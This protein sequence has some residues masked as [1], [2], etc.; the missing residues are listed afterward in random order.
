MPFKL[1]NA[2]ATILVGGQA[3]R[4]GGRLK[5]ALAIGAETI[6]ERQLAAIRDAGSTEILMIGRWPAPAI[7]GLRHF[8]DVIDG[9]G[10]LGGLYSALL[11][12]TSST[13]LV[14]AGDLPFISAQLLRQLDTMGAG[15]DA[16]VPRIDG[17]WHP[18]CAAYRRTVAGAI[19]QRIAHGRL[20]V[21]D[22]LSDMRVRELSADDLRRLD[23][24][25]MLLMNV[26]TPDDYRHAAHV[27][28]ARS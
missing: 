3:R 7:A 2:T 19:K 10:A 17:R 15:H 27:A 12:A 26:N 1:M 8:P 23:P 25:G 28:Q 18:L 14:L 6:I 16:V 4:L 13:V 21:T 5:P 11:L 24:S 22:A 9:A 20:R